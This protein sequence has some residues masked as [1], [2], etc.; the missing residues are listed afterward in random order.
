MRDV[1]RRHPLTLLA[2]LLV[3]AFG[4]RFWGTAVSTAWARLAALQTVEPYAWA[5]HEQLMYNF[6][7]E[8]AFFQ[9]IHKGYDD[10]WTW[11]GHRAITLPLTALL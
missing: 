6:A 10:A 9:T 7:H 2:A 8:G 11:S 3:V 1:L 4:V 5:V